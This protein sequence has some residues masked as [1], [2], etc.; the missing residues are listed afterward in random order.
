MRN[1]FIDSNHTAFSISKN[2]LYC[3]GAAGQLPTILIQLQNKFAERSSIFVQK[4][5]I[6]ARIENNHLYSRERAA[7]ASPIYIQKSESRC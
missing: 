5:E 4:K 1:I 6:F 2:E 7:E 3:G